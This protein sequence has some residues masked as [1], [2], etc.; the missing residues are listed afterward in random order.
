MSQILFYQTCLISMMG[1]RPTTG[2]K[3]CRR[4]EDTAWRGKDWK[5]TQRRVRGHQKIDSSSATSAASE[6]FWERSCWIEAENFATTLTLELHKKQFGLLLHVVSELA[7]GECL[8]PLSFLLSDQPHTN[9]IFCWSSNWKLGWY[10]EGRAQQHKC[11]TFLC[12]VLLFISTVPWLVTDI[13][14]VIPFS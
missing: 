4:V 8:S 11:S 5:S 7:S 10:A 9:V 14:T 2:T 6:W 1:M 3:W 13:M 12:S